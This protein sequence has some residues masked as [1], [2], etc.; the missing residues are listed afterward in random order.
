MTKIQ[1]SSDNQ[2]IQRRRRKAL[3]PEARL[4]Q[5]IALSLDLIERQIIEGTVSAS[6]LTQ[7]LKMGSAKEEL[8]IEKLRSDTK[9][10]NAKVVSIENTQRAEENYKLVLEALRGYRGEAN[11]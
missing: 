3:S 9:L 4:N 7:I 8:E 2:D 6:V 11:E 10:S 1:N 5:L